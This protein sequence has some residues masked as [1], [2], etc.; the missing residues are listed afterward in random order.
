M[1]TRGIVPGLF[2]ISM[3]ST[4][5]WLEVS[6]LVDG[7]MAEAAAEVLGRYVSGGVVIESTQITDETEGTGYPVGKLRVCGYLPVDQDL[8]KNQQRLEEALWYLGRIR[9]LPDPVFKPITETNWVEAWKDHYQPVKVGDRLLIVPAWVQL[10]TSQRIEVRIDP[11]MAFGTGTH[12]TTQLCLEIL[13]NILE[14]KDRLITS[15]NP[16]LEMV[17]VGCGSGIL[18]IAGIKLGVQRALGI[19]VDSDAVKAARENSQLNN[20]SD[21]LELAQGTVSDVRSGNYAI[22][23]AALVVANILAPVLVRLLGEGLGD[24]LTPQGKLILSGILLEQETEVL[25]AVHRYGLK[26]Q[27]RIQQ[28]DWVAMVVSKTV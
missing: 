10:E 4:A 24:L 27:S 28:D 6:L 9:P 16:T 14:Q 5:T 2:Y 11:G 15:E 8:E 1:E 20:L 22:R 7:E 18:S 17:D 23:S 13:E 12:P 19:D 21:R 25:A 26:S 3:K